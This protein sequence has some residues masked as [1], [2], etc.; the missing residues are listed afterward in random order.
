MF[1]SPGPIFLKLGPLTIRWYGLMIALGFLAATYAARRMA[2][3][4]GIDGDK[5][6]NGTLITFIGG[7]IGARLYF[8]ALSWSYFASRPAE[9]LATWNGG[10]SIHGGIVGGLLTG[11]IY[12]K[13]Q[14]LPLLTCC[15]IGGTVTALGQAI[16]RWGNFFN[17]EAFGKPVP[18]DF[19][20]K[21]YIPLESRPVSYQNAEFFHPA[22][23]YESLWD[24]TLFAVLYLLL[25]D[26]LRPYPGVTFLA[27]LG[28]YSVGRMLIEPLRTDSIMVF[29]L[30]APLIVSALCLIVS[31]I[32][33]LFLMIRYRTVQT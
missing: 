32:G 9:I 8:V 29:G 7:I 22:F 30:A 13:M 15:D 14:K 23:L 1:Q 27:Y 16:G 28:L 3:R 18:P 20:L 21:L 33:I 6:V 4:W 10:L 5:I 24:L 25:A 19:P 11:I 2:K 31:L 17:S 26:R 12:C